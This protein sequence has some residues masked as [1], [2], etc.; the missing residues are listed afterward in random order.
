MKNIKKH[1]L[2]LINGLFLIIP[3]SLMLGNL[4]S[5]LNIIL[6]CF[7][8][9]ILYFE[10]I[11]KFQVNFFD[12]I[13]L[14]FF[15]YTLLTLIIN[16]FGS[17]VS[18]EA[19]PKF[20]IVKTFSY[21]RYLA[22]Y[23]VI[24]FLMSEK[25]LRIDWFTIACACCATFVCFDIFFQFFTGKDIFGIEPA[26]TRKYSGIFG[27]EEIAGGY[28]QKFALF[29][30]FLPFIL[31][32][33]LFYRSSA[34]LIFFIIFLL[35]IALSG[36]RMPFILYI[37]SFFIF[38]F[39]NKELR[40]YFLTLFLTT[41]LLLAVAYNVSINFKENI[42]NFYIDG[43]NL[44]VSFAIKDI[45][46]EPRVVSQRAYVVEFHCF[47]HIWKQSPIFGG[48]VRYYRTY[49]GGCN[50]HPHNYYFEILTD[51]GIVGLSI[52][53]IFLF[54]FLRRIFTRKINISHFDFSTLDNKIMPFFLIF[55]IEFFPF[56]TSGSFFTTNNASVI[57]IVL[58]ILVSMISR[59][60][61]L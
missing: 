7:A 33:N 15:F 41:F 43:K 4:F 56:R 51:L 9:F 49:H 3:L 12:K 5:N 40:K 21:W 44:I 1:R 25:I 53:L 19:F 11:I 50:T 14:I 8:A 45:T 26:S 39:L 47:K 48:G 31:K 61:L 34:Q 30:F 37:F 52:V 24:R 16:F 38:I 22:L 60:K 36:N 59:K 57:F 23:L 2:I 35:G 10:K 46:K 18:S 54:M 29:S 27:A 6:L 13:I 32:K 20:I 55:L 28:L 17:Y 42:G 58:A